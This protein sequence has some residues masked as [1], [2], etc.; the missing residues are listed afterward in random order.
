MRHP[1]ILVFSGSIRGGSLNTRLAGLAAKRL[2]LADAEVTRISLA[3]YQMPLYDGDLEQE[4]GPPEAARKLKRLMQEQ[5]GIFIACPE[6]NAGITPL[7]KNTL[8]W[9]SRVGDPGDVPGAAFKNRVFCL[10]AASPSALGGIRGLMGTRTVLEVGLGALVL[11][12][13]SMVPDA[14][15]AF[16]PQGNLVNEK[17]SRALD[18][19]VQRLIRE[20]RA[21]V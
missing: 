18:A 21:L 11:P 13:M 6:Y 9:I 12:E 16:D 5:H 10:G 19:A 4:K 8:D 1:K 3:D 2:A 17:A 15:S 14:G 7:L 20:T